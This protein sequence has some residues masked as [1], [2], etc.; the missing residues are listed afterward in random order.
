MRLAP[1]DQ[2]RET[3]FEAFSSAKGRTTACAWTSGSAGTTL[4]RPCE[5]TATVKTLG[6]KRA[7][8]LI[9][10][11][12][13][14]TVRAVQQVTTI[15]TDDKKTLPGSS[16]E[17]CYKTVSTSCAPAGTTSQLNTEQN[18]QSAARK[19]ALLQ[20]SAGASSGR[21]LRR[22]KH[23]FQLA[24]VLAACVEAAAAAAHGRRDHTRLAVLAAHTSHH[25]VIA[26]PLQRLE[27]QP[28]AA[29]LAF[30]PTRVPVCFF[31]TSSTCNTNT[32]A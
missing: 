12:C 2:E 21:L 9:A 4:C 19:C 1:N 10:D 11:T 27:C 3:L 31:S 6:L 18:V 23:R 16:I 29:E 15:N 25:Q 13:K 22:R 17:T 24:P 14:C 26:Q 5:M 20:E 7:L 28:A 30:A 32:R 8:P